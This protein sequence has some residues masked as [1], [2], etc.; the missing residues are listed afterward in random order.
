RRPLQMQRHHCFSGMT[1]G[2]KDIRH[3]SP[4][5]RTDLVNSRKFSLGRADRAAEVPSH[6]GFI[7]R[8][9]LPFLILPIQLR[10]DAASRQSNRFR[11]IKRNELVLLSTLHWKA[12]RPTTIQSFALIGADH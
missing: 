8:H 7:E 1:W 9:A 11:L 5:I 10:D 2:T 6:G 12:F 3:F 4:A